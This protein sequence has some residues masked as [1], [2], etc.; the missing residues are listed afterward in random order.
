MSA[1]KVCLPSN[2]HAHVHVHIQSLDPHI[3][4]E[5]LSPVSAP[6]IVRLLKCLYSLSPL[7]TSHS[8]LNQLYLGFHY[9]A[10]LKLF[11]SITQLPSFC[12]IDFPWVLRHHPTGPLSS[13]LYSRLWPP[14]WNSFYLA[15]G[16][17]LPSPDFLLISQSVPSQPPLMSSLYLLGL[18]NGWSTPGLSPLTSLLCTQFLGDL[19]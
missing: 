6:L 3:P 1:S 19:T 13:I 14:F 8:L 2:T 7:L 12:Q 9:T 18:Y 17:V 15:S 5:I 4:L 10:P 11:L 16:N